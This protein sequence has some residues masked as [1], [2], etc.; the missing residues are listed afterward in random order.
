MSEKKKAKPQKKLSLKS[1]IEY[2]RKKA[3]RFK[4]EITK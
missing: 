3:E 4:R 1:A 2:Q